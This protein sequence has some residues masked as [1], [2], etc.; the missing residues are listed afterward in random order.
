VYVREARIAARLRLRRQAPIPG[1]RTLGLDI[2]EAW[3]VKR[4]RGLLVWGGP[5]GGLVVDGAGFQGA[6]DTVQEPT[7]TLLP[8]RRSF[9]SPARH[10]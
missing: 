5:G 3:A 10:S 9:P 7:A 4:Q 8:G 1:K 6:A 2:P